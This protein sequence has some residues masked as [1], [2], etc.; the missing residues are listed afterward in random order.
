MSLLPPHIASERFKELLQQPEV[1]AMLERQRGNINHS[2][3]P[4]THDNLHNNAP[5]SNIPSQDT[6][7]SV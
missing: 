2:E 5:A 1:M 4:N 6:I 7:R 3:F